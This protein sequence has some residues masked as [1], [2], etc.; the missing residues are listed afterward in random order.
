MT[1]VN[2]E[3]TDLLSLDDEAD[4]MPIMMSID[5]E[6]DEN[7]QDTVMEFIDP[8][9]L[10]FT[11]P[12]HTQHETESFSIPYDLP[13]TSPISSPPT[14]HHATPLPSPPPRLP[15]P[16]PLRISLRA[17][18]VT[19]RSPD[20][21]YSDSDDDATGGMASDQEIHDDSQS[22]TRGRSPGGAS[23]VDDIALEAGGLP[24]P[25]AF[26]TAVA[27]TRQIRLA[28]SPPHPNEDSIF[29]VNRPVS[30]N[31]DSESDDNAQQ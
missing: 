24:F 6:T 7:F 2:T 20:S 21:Q 15:S 28:V 10:S 30:P 29:Y 14:P 1:H 5:D 9:Y 22:L 3:L 31:S 16:S 18:P 19:P 26:I 8:N 27:C 17:M 23:F 11:S 4:A 12:E 13:T 25:S